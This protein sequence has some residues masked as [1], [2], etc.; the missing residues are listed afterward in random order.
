MVSTNDSASTNDN[1]SMDEKLDKWPWKYAGYRVFSRWVTSDPAFFI[2]RR[3]GSLNARV[4]LCLQN[5]IVMLEKE[6]D[7]LDHEY[8]GEDRPN[9]T[10]NGSFWEDPSEERRKLICGTLR[11]KLAEYNTFVNGY[12]QL[13]SR[14]PVNTTDVGLVQGW[15]QN[16]RPGAID[17]EEAGY[18]Y[19]KDDLIPVQPKTRSWFRRRLE[20]TLLLNRP[21]M[22]YFFDRE[23]RDHDIIKDGR[24]IWQDDKK[25]EM[26]SSVV[27][28]LV[29]LA[30]LIGP[31]WILDRVI[32]TR[33]RLGIITTFIV[34]FFA[35]VAVATTAKPWE[36]LAATAAYSAVLMV[37]LQLGPRSTT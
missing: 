32:D 16:A 33:T 26:L 19:C 37:F 7:T 18:I 35:V 10:N 23:P 1:A 13:V 15:F 27:T 8:I 34:V 30:M 25:I 29:G 5:E 17:D 36:S 2:V 20:S 31:L 3:F 22:R 4:I 9:N 24:T 6:L 11:T 14:Q 28:A 12:A 21:F